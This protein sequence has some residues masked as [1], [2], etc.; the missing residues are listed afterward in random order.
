[1][2]ERRKIV[3]IISSL[4]I[5]GAESLLVDLLAHP[6][7]EQFEHHVIYFHHGPNVTRLKGMKIPTYYVRGKWT[8][9]GPSFFKRLK[10]LLLELKPD[11]IHTALWMANFV[12]RIYGKMLGIPVVSVLHLGIDQDGVV[13][14]LLDHLTFSLTDQVIA[15][16]NTV[17][18]TL[19]ERPRWLP[20][21]RI[22][23]IHNGIDIEALHRMA[24]KSRVSRAAL[25][26]DEHQ[27]VI[28]S[29]GRFIPRK[30]YLLLLESFAE[31]CFAYPRTQLLLIGFGP[32]EYE[33]KQYAHQ[34]GM[35]DRVIFILEQPASGY[36]PLFDIFVLPSLQ[37]GLS[38]AL[39]EAMSF[40]LPCI[41]SHN[42]TEHEV[43]RSGQNGMLVPTGD[44]PAMTKALHNFL[45][46][47]AM[48]E[49]FATH[50]RTTVFE[51]FNIDR[52]ASSY[53]D[54]F[55]KAILEQEEKLIQYQ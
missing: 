24:Q 27:V 48:R 21:R 22:N 5:G 49:Q 2:S 9:Y 10:K 42:N 47:P 14:N 25:K 55:E 43:I 3:H 7:M 23:V 28:G 30:N 33:L 13:R 12:G 19:Y 40:G 45:R 32:L 4:K 36:Y 11:C 6:Q 18:H 31:I 26:L 29:V 46:Y 17:A 50:A 54:V 8:R 39:L 1:M 52:M 41:V 38:I 34:R 44:R 16:S 53:K 37:E 51:R 15:V 35:S 20:S